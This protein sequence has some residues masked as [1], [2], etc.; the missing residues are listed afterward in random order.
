VSVTIPNTE[1]FSCYR[2][3]DLPRNMSPTPWSAASENG[4]LGG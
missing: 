3:A 1:S 4:H 2:V